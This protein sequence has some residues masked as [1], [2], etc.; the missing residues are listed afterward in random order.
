MWW[1][2]DKTINDTNNGNDD[3][4][5]IVKKDKTNINDI[6]S[7]IQNKK[8]GSDYDHKKKIINTIYTGD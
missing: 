2:D 4:E 3:T 7:N 5:K 1:C 8:T 6:K